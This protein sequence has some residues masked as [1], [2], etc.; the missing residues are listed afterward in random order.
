[1]LD[2]N[3]VS[4][5]MRPEP[6]PVVYDWSNKCDEACLFFSAIGEAELRYGIEIM[7][8]GQRRD[9][10]AAKLESLL[11]D[12]FAGRILPFDRKAAGIFARLG[13]ARR[14]AGQPFARADVQ[15]AAI[16]RSRSMSAATTDTGGFAGMGVEIFN[17]W[18]DA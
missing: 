4:E 13:A 6:A 9:M 8:A 3:V 2:T 14:S 17:P 10:L 5:L 16:A 18:T 11:R 7:P 15:I 1:M 12:I